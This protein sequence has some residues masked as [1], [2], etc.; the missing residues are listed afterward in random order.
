MPDPT[1]ETERWFIRRGLPHF[2]HR[3]N[4]AEDV[5]TRTLPAL[6]A[7][8]FVEG[9]VNAPKSDFPLWLDAIAI[10]GA[11]ALLVG[12]WAVANVVRGLHPI[13]RP[14]RV[15]FIELAIFVVVP[16]IVPIVGGGQWRSGLATMGLNVC[17]VG[18]VF[19]VTSYGLVPMARWAIGHGADQVFSAINVL[20]RALPVLL[21][22]VIVV[23]LNTEAWQIASELE[24]VGVAI[25]VGT[26]FVLGA[27]F[28]AIRV[29]RQVTRFSQEPWDE[30][31]RRAEHTPVDP[32]LARLEPDPPP[33]PTLS[34]REWGNVGLVVLVS[35]G[36]LVVIVTAVMFCFLVAFGAAAIHR[37]VVTIWLGRA[38]DVIVTI[39][40]LSQEMVVTGELIKVSAFL[41]GFCGLSFTVS[42]LTDAGY[43]D[44]F[45][46]E[47]DDE[48]ADAFAVRAVYR[49]VTDREDSATAGTSTMPPT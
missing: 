25:V 33:P 1:V 4:A 49:E 44:E 32:L 37:D 31:R 23:F 11:V 38:P 2:I 34:R 48:I 3:Y 30:I 17:L 29:P 18:L 14:E 40:L 10:L 21:L 16:G 22:I 39:R 47:L 45:L 5:F 35:E 19:A 27:A 12:S 13:S 24:W 36:I 8:A 41:A 43:Q 20:L 42:L 9:V 6:V 28:A 46:A 26:F 15:G 7:I